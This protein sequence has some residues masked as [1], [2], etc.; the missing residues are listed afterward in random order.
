MTNSR[1]RL[2]GEVVRAKMQKTVTVQ[3]DQTKQHP[4]YGKIIRTQ[5]EYLVHDE[6]GC[7]LG[8]RVK[9]VE[10]RPISRR[11]RWVVEEVLRRADL[12]TVQVKL[13]EEQGSEAEAEERVQNMLDAADEAEDQDAEAEQ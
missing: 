2:V 7:R 12:E 5:K 8:D 1:R 13:E 3:V 4:L 6:E 9:I 11:K 10:S